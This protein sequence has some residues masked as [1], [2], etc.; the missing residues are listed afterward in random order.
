MSFNVIQNCRTV[1]KIT[2]CT[3]NLK[4]ENILNTRSFQKALKYFLLPILSS[5]CL[6]FLHS[7]GPVTEEWGGGGGGGGLSLCR[8]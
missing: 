3:W 7:S 6:S 2:V 1:Y 5:Q 4:L 8:R